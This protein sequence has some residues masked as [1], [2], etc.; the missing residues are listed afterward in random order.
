MTFLT[1]R[2][3][4][5]CEKCMFAHSETD[6][7]TNMHMQRVLKA[8]GI[9]VV[10][11]DVPLSCQCYLILAGVNYLPSI[12]INYGEPTYDFYRNATNLTCR[13]Q[14]DPCYLNYDLQQIDRKYTVK[15]R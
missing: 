12:A 7:S 6:I 2:L 11:L 15:P 5:L 14:L 8:Q 1:H 10:L 4:Q 3:R 9:S 13:A